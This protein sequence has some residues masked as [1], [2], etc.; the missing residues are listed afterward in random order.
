MIEFLTRKEVAN[1]FRVTTRTIER[2]I[3]SGKLKGLKLGT[4]KSSRWRISR[5]EVDKFT[6]SNNSEYENRK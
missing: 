2:W 6:N 4:S 3:N 1:F 5:E